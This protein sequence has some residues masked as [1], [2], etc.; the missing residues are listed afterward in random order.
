MSY[1]T[2]EAK[3]RQLAKKH[4]PA[5]EDLV[6]ELERSAAGIVGQETLTKEQKAKIRAKAEALAHGG[7]DENPALLNQFMADI[8]NAIERGD[9]EAYNPRTHAPAPRGSVKGHEHY[10]E[11]INS[12]VDDWH[13]AFSP[14]GQVDSKRAEVHNAA[15]ARYRFLKEAGKEITTNKAM[16]KDLAFRETLKKSDGEPMDEETIRGHL[17]KDGTLP[18]WAPPKD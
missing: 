9:L 14:S 5:V 6:R 4:A 16:A 12:A 13:S 1:I 15:D 10:Y 3:A 18:A 2:I 7:D 11:V 17:N 8:V